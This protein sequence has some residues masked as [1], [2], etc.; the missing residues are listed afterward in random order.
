MLLEP[1]GICFCGN[2]GCVSTATDECG[3]V[4]DLFS[5]DN[6]A[7]G[8]YSDKFVISKCLQQS[9]ITDKFSQSFP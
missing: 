9:F 6:R 5:L 1:V 8:Q 7:T 4:H 3:Q 2:A